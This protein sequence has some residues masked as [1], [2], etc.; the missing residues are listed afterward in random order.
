MTSFE[1]ICPQNP[2]KVGGNMQF[3]AKMPKYKDRTISR[4]VNPIKPKFED[5]AETTSYTSWMVYNYPKPNP[6]WLTAAIL[7]IVTTS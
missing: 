5:K 1:K 3:Q 4:T 6:T 2:L 7:K